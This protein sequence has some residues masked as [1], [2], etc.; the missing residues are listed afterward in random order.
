MSAGAARPCWQNCSGAEDDEVRCID[1]ME[2]ALGPYA[3]L[4]LNACCS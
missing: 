1:A 4:P 3:R 2:D